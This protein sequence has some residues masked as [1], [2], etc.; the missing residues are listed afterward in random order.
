MT[1]S[2]TK[3]PADDGN[4]AAPYNILTDKLPCRLPF[5]GASNDTL[6]FSRCGSLL[7]NSKGYL[8]ALSEL[9]PQTSPDKVGCSSTSYAL[10]CLELFPLPGKARPGKLAI[11]H[12]GNIP[13]RLTIFVSSPSLK[14]L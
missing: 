7:T 12:G 3:Q 11:W 8:D 1:H 13:R 6:M 9:T 10:D 2:V 4:V 14:P 5:C